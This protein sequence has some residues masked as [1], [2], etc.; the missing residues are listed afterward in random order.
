MIPQT[1]IEA[2]RPPAASPADGSGA[3]AGP[4]RRGR[5]GGVRR[6]GQGP[7][8]VELGKLITLRVLGLRFGREFS[9]R[10][11]PSTTPKDPLGL[12]R[13][14]IQSDIRGKGPQGNS[15]GRAVVRIRFPKCRP[16]RG[17]NCGGHA[18]WKKGS[19]VDIDISASS[20]GRPA[21]TRANQGRQALQ[22]QAHRG[23]VGSWGRQAGSLVGKRKPR[24]PIRRHTARRRRLQLRQGAWCELPRWRQGGESGRE[25]VLLAPQLVPAAGGTCRP[26]TPTEVGSTIVAWVGWEYGEARCSKGRRWILKVATY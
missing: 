3:R 1:L 22:P 21:R 12:N 10:V 11:Q 2:A 23:G 15:S 19:W 17:A 18:P 6:E 24:Y 26:P 7:K 9:I 5:V 8:R 14:L 25:A 16:Q 20:G 13:A 4:A